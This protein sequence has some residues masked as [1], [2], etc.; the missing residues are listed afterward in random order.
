MR[1]GIF[2]TARLGS[3]RLKRKHFLPVNDQP[4][5]VFLIKRITEAFRHEI[6]N[7]DVSVVIVTSDENENREFERFN[8][9][10]VSVFYGSKDNIPL[11]HLQ[12][13]EYF[14]LDA[15]I[16]VDGDD[17]LCSQCGMREVFENLKAGKEYVRTSGLP[18]G[19]NSMGYSKAFLERSLHG[20][21]YSALETGWGRI[22]DNKNLCTCE[23]PINSRGAYLRFTLDY[24]DDYLFFKALIHAL[25]HRV[26]SLTDQ[27]VIDFVV[28]NHFNDL[29]KTVDE[30]YWEN[31][32]KSID[33]EN[34]NAS[35]M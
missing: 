27:D 8:N 5:I 30:S 4:I 7:N 10:G 24:Y 25:G 33:N 3:S 2:I 23:L 21:S 16:S 31:V 20:C 9:M 34:S 29:N 32:K 13:A 35:S 19:V 11:R 6:L 15:I 1:I 28:S 12:A 14:S 26:F 18:F 17:I 22:F